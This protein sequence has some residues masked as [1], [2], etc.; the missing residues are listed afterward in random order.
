VPH[1]GLAQIFAGQQAASFFGVPYSDPRYPDV[2][3][4]VQVGVVYT[5]GSKIA[6][7]GGD[8]PADRDVPL[9]VYAPGTVKPGL[10]GQYVETTSVAPTILAL[11]GLNPNDLQAVQIEHTPV[12]PG[13]GI[14]P[15]SLS[16][17]ATNSAG[18]PLT[19]LYTT[20]SLS[21]GTTVLQSCYSP[22]AFTVDGGQSYVVTVA[23]FA[24]ETFAKWS[25]GA[26]SAYPWGGSHY[27][28]VQEGRGS[29][30]TSTP[31]SLTAVYSP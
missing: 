8:N 13:L 4:I 2:F 28:T 21:G 29:G 20:L 25:D 31:V 14:S 11:L 19:G 5:T 17:S 22:C 9:L 24:G 3:G 26:G 7:H 30:G 18:D 10:N 27:V 12:L 1:S 16:V 6:E 23:N 15:T